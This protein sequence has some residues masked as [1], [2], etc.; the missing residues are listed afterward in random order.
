MTHVI[1]HANCL[2]GLAAAYAAYLK[3]QELGE[4]WS[5]APMVYGVPMDLNPC[6][7]ET[8]YLLDFSFKRDQM[9]TLM[10]FAKEVI[11]LDHHKTAHEEIGDWFE[12]DQ[13]KSGAVLAWEHFHPNKPVPEVFLHIQDRDL[14][15]W[16]RDN[17]RQIT[18]FLYS[19]TVAL[20]PEDAFA[21]FDKFATLND[22]GSIITMG[23]GIEVYVESQVRLNLQNT[24]PITIAGKVYQ[25]VNCNHALS[26]DTGHYIA[27]TIGEGVG[28][29]YQINRD[30]VTFSLRSIG[31]NDVAAICATYGGGG[32][33]N[34][35]GFSVSMGH[36]YE[37]LKC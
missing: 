22:M 7:G 31:E 16:E 25:A 17:T 35:A 9:A 10:N 14:W 37:M 36:F 26:S 24:H 6:V 1:Y 8:V 19:L 12:I 34:A 11:V 27:N 20:P 28:V 3:A 5:F 4:I 13:T 32:H 30:K 21:N 15:Q 18:A 23:T 29:T 2:D 33:R